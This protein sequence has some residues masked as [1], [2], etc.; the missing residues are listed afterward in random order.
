MPPS[1]PRIR[2][3][4]DRFNKDF[5]AIF[6]NGQAAVA[7]HQFHHQTAS[8]TSMHVPNPPTLPALKSGHES[9]TAKCRHKGQ[10]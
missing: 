3:M 4:N 2:S 10:P 9:L 6:G 8:R 7:A 1:M 5:A